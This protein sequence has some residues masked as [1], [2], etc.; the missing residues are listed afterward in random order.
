PAP[1]LRTAVFGCRAMSVNMA[2]A[3]RGVGCRKANADGTTGGGPMYYLRDGLA[4]SGRKKLGR[5]LAVLYAI[6]TLV[7]VFGS[8]NPFQA[9]Q[10]AAIVST[11]SG[12]EFLTENQWLIGLVMAVLT[13]V[14][15]LGGVKKISQ[16]TSALGRAHV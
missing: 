7:G 14:V 9:N 2:E 6:F 5:I 11:S 16:W 12:S 3:A 13:A 10:V 4:S 15:I 1:A 8:G